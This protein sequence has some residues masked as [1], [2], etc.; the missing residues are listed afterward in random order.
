MSW[1]Q[2]NVSQIC[3]LPRLLV[4][5]TLRTPGNRAQCFFYRACDLD[6]HAL[7]RPVP[8]VN[9]HPDQR[10]ID[11][12]EKRDRDRPRGKY[13]PG[14]QCHQKKQNGPR[15]PA[16][17]MSGF[18]FAASWVVGCVAESSAPPPD[19]TDMPF[20]NSMFPTITTAAPV[21]KPSPVISAD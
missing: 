19:F 15:V 3:A 18:H 1:P 4:D 16:G 14:N 11:V 7:D 6:N 10:K 5:F 12:R 21:P 13:A 20:S 2:S 8:R 9:I 17:P